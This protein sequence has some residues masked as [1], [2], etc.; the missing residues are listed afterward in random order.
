MSSPNYIGG[1]SAAFPSA[2]HDD[3]I[4]DQFSR[5]AELSR[6]RLSCMATRS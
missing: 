5:Q 2:T 6:A 4:R 3:L 1:S